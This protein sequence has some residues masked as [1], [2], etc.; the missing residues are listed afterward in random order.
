[1]NKHIAREELA[2]A[3]ALLTR[4]HLNHFFCGDKHLI[5]EVF[6]AL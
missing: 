1:M 3:F 6:H 4:A 5:E 2:L